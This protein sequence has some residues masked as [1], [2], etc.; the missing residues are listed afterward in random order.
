MSAEEA[1]RLA[2]DYFGRTWGRNP[3]HNS[4][5]GEVQVV[6]VADTIAAFERS[7]G[8]PLEP[9]QRRRAERFYRFR[10]VSALPPLDCG[11]HDVVRV[12]KATGEI[13]E[14]VWD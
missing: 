7:T 9:E 8:R 10:F 2:T 11:S 14:E 5:T 13:T 4:F 6:D 12:N 3:G 1:L